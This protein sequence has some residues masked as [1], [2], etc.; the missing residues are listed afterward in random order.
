MLNAVKVADESN[1][2]SQDNTKSAKP[3]I[4]RDFKIVGKDERRK[5]DKP[6]DVQ[7]LEPG[8]ESRED[9]TGLQILIVDDNRFHR[10]LIRNALV[11]QG[12]HR[13]WEAEDTKAAEK[14]LAD[15]TIDLII[16][17]NNMPDEKGIPFTE[18]LR[19]GKTSANSKVPIV[20]LSAYGDE[21]VIMAARNAGVH[22][23]VLKPFNV[24]TLIKRIQETFRHPRD[25]IIAPG[26]VGP[27]RRW[28]QKLDQET[29]A[30][31]A[32]ANAERIPPGLR[33]PQVVEVVD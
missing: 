15:E 20:M 33:R 32:A 3:G 13:H 16:M 4:S 12:I 31:K 30:A 25:F 10:S 9:L 2:F 6:A 29:A 7:I 27:D 23:Y 21:R 1:E 28:K 11:S 8:Y 26:Y 22:E 17:D 19:K 5:K 24:V 14:V 18:R